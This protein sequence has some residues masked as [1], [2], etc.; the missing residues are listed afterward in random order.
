MNASVVVPLDS[1]SFPLVDP[2]L[3][4]ELHRKRDNI[5]DIFAMIARSDDLLPAHWTLRGAFAGLGTLIFT[6]YEGFH[7]ACMAEQVTLKKNI[8]LV[9]VREDCATEWTYRSGWL[10]DLSWSPCR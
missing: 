3:C 5:V 2:T 9:F 6:R 7:K 8:E 1:L 10:S 4:L